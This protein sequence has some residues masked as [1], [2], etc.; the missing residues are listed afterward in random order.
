[1][2]VLN[3]D[4]DKYNMLYKVCIWEH[5]NKINLDRMRVP[6]VVGLGRTKQEALDNFFR[7]LYTGKDPQIKEMHIKDNTLG[8]NNGG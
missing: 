4:I 1:M 7:L 8:E 5:K 2:G 6:D 3:V